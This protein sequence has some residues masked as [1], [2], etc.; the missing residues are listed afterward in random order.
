MH[1]FRFPVPALLDV[2]GF[3]LAARGSYSV[4]ALYKG[5]HL[6]STQGTKVRGAYNPQ[7]DMFRFLVAPS[8]RVQSLV[9]HLTHTA[10]PAPL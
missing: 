7:T 1:E 8:F 4:T 6:F 5:T 2:I 10:G 9:R 3:V